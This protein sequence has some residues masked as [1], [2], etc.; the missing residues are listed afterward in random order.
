MSL[1]NILVTVGIASVLAAF[2][3]IGK[4]LQIL[5]DLQKTTG[6]IKINVKV[7][8]DYLT[9]ASVDFNHTEFQ[10]YSPFKLTTQGKELIKKLGFD[11]IF[12]EHTADFCGFI[13]REKPKL[14]YDVE[15][16]A[17]SSISAFY[18]KDYMNSLKVFFYNNPDRNLKNVAPTLGIYLRDK[19][20]EKHPEITE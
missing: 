8:S 5:E 20:H 3:Y 12:E 13:D 15:K 19:Y 10:A 4:K 17:I 9:S 18:D 6:K 16:A 2:I 14:K 11:R 1:F 7:I